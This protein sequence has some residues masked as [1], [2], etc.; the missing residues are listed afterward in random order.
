MQL[1]TF[2]TLDFLLARL[3]LRI[4]FMHAFLFQPPRLFLL[5][6]RLRDASTQV[7]PTLMISIADDDA[8]CRDLIFI[9][10]RQSLSVKNAPGRKMPAFPASCRHFIARQKRH[11]RY[12]Y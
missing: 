10:L 1:T 12:L 2:F 4:H 7:T 8:R 11:G 9:G 3:I 5:L 6:C